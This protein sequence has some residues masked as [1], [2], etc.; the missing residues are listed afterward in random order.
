MMGFGSYST[1]LCYEEQDSICY[2]S[3]TWAKSQ[4]WEA[5]YT[6]SDVLE[7]IEGEKGERRGTRHE[8]AKKFK[9]GNYCS[10]QTIVKSEWKPYS[11]ILWISKLQR[12]LKLCSK[13]QNRKKSDKSF[14][15]NFT[16]KRW[17]YGKF[18]SVLW[19]PKN[20][21]VILDNREFHCLRPKALKW[22]D[23]VLLFVH[24]VTITKMSKSFQK[25]TSQPIQYTTLNSHNIPKH[26]P[27]KLLIHKS[28]LILTAHFW[29]LKILVNDT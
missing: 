7:E 22:G 29:I 8:W 27:S 17:H 23:T 21:N 5:L 19:Y 18:N 25:D 28:T 6:V 15:S 20:A 24:T 9:V 11:M 2:L 1:I 10:I 4:S 14:R 12:F 3:G 13:L 26:T 16:G